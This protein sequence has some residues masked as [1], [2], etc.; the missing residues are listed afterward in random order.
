MHHSRLAAVLIDCRGEDLDA[1]G[2]FWSRALG[3]AQKVGDTVDPERYRVLATPDH[4]LRCEVQLVAHDSRVHLDIETDDIEAE[5]SRLQALG[6]REAQRIAS[7]V[8]MEAPTGQRFC[9][10]RPQRADF[11]RGANRWD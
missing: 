9:V 2:D 4:Q 6:A 5:V 7:W 1:A 10:V 11:P 8:V 3:Y